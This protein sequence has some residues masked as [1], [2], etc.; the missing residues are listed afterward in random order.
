MVTS[1]VVPL[2]G[3][4]NRKRIAMSAE[5]ASIITKIQAEPRLLPEMTSAPRARSS[6]LSIGRG[7]TAVARRPS[8]RRRGA[9]S[10]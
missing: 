7:G 8:I 5:I 10:G 1:S 4:L 3:A 2:I 6:V 9:Y